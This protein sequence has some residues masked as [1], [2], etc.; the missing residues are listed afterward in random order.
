VL[1]ES[2]RS[3]ITTLRGQL[4]ALPKIVVT[5]AGAMVA[6]ATAS[7]VA[8]GGVAPAAIPF[9]P[10]H[11]GPPE[12]QPAWQV[13]NGSTPSI[14][15]NAGLELQLLQQVGDWAQVRASNGWTGWVDARR[16]LPR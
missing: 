9:V 13:P 15:L 12:G 5:Q 16:L 6:A 8:G 4:A 3:L 14:G 11:R 1:L 2:N 7:M 10:S